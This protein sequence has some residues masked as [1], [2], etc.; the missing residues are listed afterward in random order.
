MRWGDGCGLPLYLAQGYF[1]SKS[2]FHPSIS[3]TLA[4]STFFS[5]GEAGA[6]TAS[7][8]MSNQRANVPLASVIFF[9]RRIFG[10]S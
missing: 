8:I 6:A 5:S 4:S 10:H 3:L 1:L 9:W 7:A 2:A